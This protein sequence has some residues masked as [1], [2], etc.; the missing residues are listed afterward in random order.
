MSLQ[1]RQAPADQIDLLGR[2]LLIDD[3][4]LRGAESAGHHA[5]RGMVDLNP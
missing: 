3:A 1:L 2:S 5:V 4:D